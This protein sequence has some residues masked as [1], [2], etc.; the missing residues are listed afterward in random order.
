MCVRVCVCVCSR[1]CVRTLAAGTPLPPGTPTI[2]LSQLQQ[3]SLALQGQHGQAL[4]VTPQPQQG[5]QAVFR[6]PAAVSL[7]GDMLCMLPRLCVSCANH[8]F[9]NLLLLPALLTLPFL[10]YNHAPNACRCCLHDFY[11]SYHSL[12]SL[13]HPSS[14]T[15]CCSPSGPGRGV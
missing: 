4:A 10:L 1:V 14:L 7:T 2:P 13:L 3:H 11:L 5:Q 15:Y 6:F 9:I 8:V 12:S